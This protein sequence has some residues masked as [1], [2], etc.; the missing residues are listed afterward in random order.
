MLTILRDLDSVLEVVD[1][2]VKVPIQQNVQSSTLGYS[3]PL[4]R[5]HAHTMREGETDQQVIKDSD[6]SQLT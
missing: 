2:E 5:I 3:V 4:G 6:D 1:P